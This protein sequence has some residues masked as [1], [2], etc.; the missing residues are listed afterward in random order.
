[1]TLRR[2]VPQAPTLRSIVSP[3]AVPT[4]LRGAVNGVLRRWGYEWSEVTFAG[5]AMVPA[6]ERRQLAPGRQEV[7][8]IA[9]AAAPLLV[10]DELVTAGGRVSGVAV[11]AFSGG[12][13]PATPY[14]ARIYEYLGGRDDGSGSGRPPLPSSPREK[15]AGAPFTG[16][17]GRA[18]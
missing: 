5:T 17:R 10:G 14:E 15:A 16:R 9:V 7:W 2:E 11:S 13:L 18:G 6:D 3:E 12:V 8:V 4:R 1:M